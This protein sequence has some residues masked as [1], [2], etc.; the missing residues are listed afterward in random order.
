[1]HPEKKVGIVHHTHLAKYKDVVCAGEFIPKFINNKSG[2]YTPDEKCLE[3]ASENFKSYG[4]SIHI[5]KFK[6]ENI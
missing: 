4:Y 2:H 5:T 6:P 3:Y 1:M